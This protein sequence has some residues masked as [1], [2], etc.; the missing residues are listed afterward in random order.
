MWVWIP[1]ALLGI[2]INVQIQQLGQQ[3]PDVAGG[4]PNYLAHL[5]PDMRWLT[6][7]AAIGYFLS[8]VAVIPVNAIILAELIETYLPPLDVAVTGIA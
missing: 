7:Y 2:V 5:L 1:G 8:W 6:S 3:L 4:T